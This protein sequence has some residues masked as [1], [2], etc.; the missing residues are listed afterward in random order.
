MLQGFVALPV[1]AP[2]EAVQKFRQGSRKRRLQSGSHERERMRD[3]WGI[4]VY[5]YLDSAS[6]RVKPDGAFGRVPHRTGGVAMRLVFTGISLLGL[7]ALGTSAMSAQTATFAYAP[8]T[9]HYRL[10]TEVHR[11]QAQGVQRHVA[12]AGGHGSGFPVA[13]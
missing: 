4:V 1:L 12:A 11:E 3:S 9:Q 2:I 10:V 6:L 7:A 13:R 8:G 5:D